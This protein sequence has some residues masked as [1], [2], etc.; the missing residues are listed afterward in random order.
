VLGYLSMNL[1]FG[2]L[3]ML[4][5]VEN[6][7]NASMETL[8]GRWMSAI[9][10]SVQTLT[11][12]G[13]GSLFPNSPSAW[14]IAAV[15]GVFGILGFSLISAVLYARFARPKANLVYSENAIIAPY[16]EGWS[17]QIRLANRR[18]SLMVEVEARI[19]LVMADVD[20]QGE[21]LNYYNLPLQLDRVTFMPLSWTLVHPINTD[22]PLAGLSAEDLRTRRAEFLVI[23]KGMDEGYMGQ[24]FTRRSVRHDELVWGARYIR[25]FSVKDGATRLDLNKLSDLMPVEAPSR[26]PG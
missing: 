23:I 12:V 2:S 13:Y 15:E 9:G 1:V 8:A 25:A 18:T 16:K 11:T 3:Y 17:F 10:M 21:R 26:L 24:V 6:I 5:G 4:I 7:G 22:S 19:L 20:D 14:F